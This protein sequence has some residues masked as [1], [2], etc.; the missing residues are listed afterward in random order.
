MGV[1]REGGRR[2]RGRRP[3]EPQEVRY[4]TR[5]HTGAT[6]W[7]ARTLMQLV[8]S[9]QSPAGA[10]LRGSQRAVSGKHNR[11]TTGFPSSATTRT[12]CELARDFYFPNSFKL[13]HLISLYHIFL[14]SQKTAPSGWRCSSVGRALAWYTQKLWVQSPTCRNQPWQCMLVILALKRRRPENQKF[15][16]ILGKLNYTAS[17]S[18]PGVGGDVVKF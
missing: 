7:E 18:Q 17:A 2:K 10:G 1:W 9:N 11:Q 15:K 13:L 3:Q 4:L 14:I 12:F 6:V 5:T 8:P 16:V